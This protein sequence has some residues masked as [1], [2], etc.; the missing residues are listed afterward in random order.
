[1]D[2]LCTLAP[3]S[4]TYLREASTY[5]ATESLLVSSVL[6]HAGKPL[7]G[8]Q[9]ITNQTLCPTGVRGICAVPDRLIGAGSDGDRTRFQKSFQCPSTIISDFY[10]SPSALTYQQ[11]Y[12]LGISL[13]AHTAGENYMS[14]PAFMTPYPQDAGVLRATSGIRP[15]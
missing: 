8:D 11:T 15:L 5:S 12:A 7:I 9:L 2:V 1:M 3:P 13:Y 4:G 6:H 10:D 14:F